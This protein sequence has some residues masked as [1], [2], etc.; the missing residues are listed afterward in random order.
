LFKVFGTGELDVTVDAR[1]QRSSINSKF[2]TFRVMK[3]APRVGF[4][5]TTL[6]LTGTRIYQ[7]SYR[8]MK[9]IFAIYNRRR[10]FALKVTLFCSQRV[11]PSFPNHGAQREPIRDFFVELLLATSV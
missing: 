10:G 7:L 9:L 1:L 3:V 11:Q 6:C 2:P 4:E 5:P 8:G